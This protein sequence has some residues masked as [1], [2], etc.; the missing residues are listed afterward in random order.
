MWLAH[1]DFVIPLAIQHHVIVFFQPRARAKVL[2]K[3]V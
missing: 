3:L 2:A 1:S